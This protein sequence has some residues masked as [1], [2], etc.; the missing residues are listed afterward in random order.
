MGLEK[1]G[2]KPTG[3]IGKIIGYVDYFNKKN[4]SD[5][6]RILDIGCGGGKFIKYLS[7]INDS[8]KLFGLDHSPEMVELSKKI[9]K[10]AIDK[11]QVTIIQGSVTDIPI[12]NN[13]IDLATAFETVQF[14]PDIDKSFSEIVRLLKS[15][16]SFLIINR[17]PPEG[18]KW[19]R[20]AKI[21]NDKEY[22]AKLEK[23]GF[24]EVT[25]DLDFKKGWIII[26]ATK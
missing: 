26:K 3:I 4:I 21:K 22:I 14:W 16:G 25:V 13:K 9:N 15:R 11:K 19:W 6:Y 18:S 17:Y 23:A 5:N 8:Y 10:Q 1:Q 7:D 12:E 20:M 24:C 2:S